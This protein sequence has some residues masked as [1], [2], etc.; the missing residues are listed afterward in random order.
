MI[1]GFDPVPLSAMIA[2]GLLGGLVLRAARV[3]K[4]T[5]PLL[6]AFASLVLGFVFVNPAHLLLVLAWLAA[7]VLFA[8]AAQ[9]RVGLARVGRFLALAAPLALLFNLWWIVPAAL[10][11]TGP[12]LSDQFSAPDVAVWSWTHARNTIPNILGLTS[13]WAWG[14]PDTTPS[15][16]ASSGRHWPP[17]VH[18]RGGGRRWGSC[19]RRESSSESRSA[20]RVWAWPRSSFRRALKHHSSA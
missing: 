10:T 19:S 9:G 8:W 2:A 7:C 20:L 5:S 13:S 18:A 1:T 3:G 17:S 15:P 4:R 12:V 11:L 16:R 6:F 14:T